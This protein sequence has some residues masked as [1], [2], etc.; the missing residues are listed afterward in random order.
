MAE[1][2]LSSSAAELAALQVA[3]EQVEA[4]L[5]QN[6]EESE[7]LLKQCFDRAVRQ[8]HVLCGGPPAIGE[9]NMDY[10]VHQGR[11][12]PSSEVAALIG[13]ETEP[14]GTEEGEAEAQGVEAEAEEG[15]LLYT[16][17][18]ADE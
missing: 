16:S 2:K 11:L 10:E 15:C 13:Q 4:E 3:K 1:E 6:Y 7:E 18:A 17:D 8:A 12:V 5:D 9:F 14:A